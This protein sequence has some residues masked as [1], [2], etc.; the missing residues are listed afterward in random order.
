MANALGLMGFFFLMFSI[1]GVQ[2][3]AGKFH[4]CQKLGTYEP[5][6]TPDP[7]DN[8]TFVCP[9]SDFDKGLCGEVFFL[10]LSGFGNV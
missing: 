10:V 7:L 1:L 3:F 8:I 5:N 4:Y 9:E 2:L 6:G